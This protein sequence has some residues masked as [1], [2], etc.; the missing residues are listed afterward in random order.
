MQEDGPHGE[1]VTEDTRDVGEVSEEV[2]NEEAEENTHT[3]RQNSPHCDVADDSP[4]NAIP[5]TS[6]TTA[7]EAVSKGPVTGETPT[8]QA[9]CSR[10]TRAPVPTVLTTKPKPGT[11]N[12]PILI[13]DTPPFRPTDPITPVSPMTL[14]TQLP[15]L[16]NA[17]TADTATLVAQS[18]LAEYDRLGQAE[19]Y[20][21]VGPS[22]IAPVAFTVPPLPSWSYLD[23]GLSGSA[24]PYG[25]ARG[26]PFMGM[27]SGGSSSPVVNPL[28]SPIADPQRGLSISSLLGPGLSNQES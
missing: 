12:A 17:L 3:S 4:A 25:V 9:E 19:G 22:A 7:Q 21:G 13:E 10:Q 8:S 15:T 18:A 20:A 11:I 14:N 24:T 16:G 26:N 5:A 28:S 23:R 27:A 2:N 6:A 1:I